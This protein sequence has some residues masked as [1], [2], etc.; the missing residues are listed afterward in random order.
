LLNAWQGQAIVA[1]QGPWTAMRCAATAGWALPTGYGAD[2]PVDESEQSA[3]RV[4]CLTH[5]VEQV[6]A[7]LD[8]ATTSGSY[9]ADAVRPLLCWAGEPPPATAPLDPQAYPVYQQAQP[10]PDLGRYNQLLR[11]QQEGPA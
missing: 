8:L 2:N 7:A 4:L 10:R 6:G 3:R 11:A 5:R 9:S 1:G